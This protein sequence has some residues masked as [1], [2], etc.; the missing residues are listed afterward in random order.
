MN[1]LDLMV[2]F[3][4][5]IRQSGR[6]ARCRTTV[7]LPVNNLP[8]IRIGGREASEIL[9][10]GLAS[11]GPPLPAWREL[12]LD[13]RRPLRLRP[14]EMLPPVEGDHLTGHRRRRQNET[15]RRCNLP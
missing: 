14:S 11:R 8:T 2:N 10:V 9:G 13:D 6:L 7:I 12:L 4:Q 3:S 5:T 1:F 15:Q